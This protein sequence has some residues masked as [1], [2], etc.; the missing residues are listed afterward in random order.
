MLPNYLMTL[1]TGTMKNKFSAKIVAARVVGPAHRINN[2]PC[3]DY[4]QYARG[5]NLIAVLSDGAGS[6]EHGKIGARV[7]CKKLCDLLKNADFKNIENEIKN[8]ISAAR[9]DLII[10]RFNK[11]KDEHGLNDF[12][13][14]LVGVV[15]HQ[16]RGIFFHIGDGAALSIHP[17]NEVMVSRPE[18]GYFSCETFFFTQNCWKSNLRFTRF[19]QA[20]VIFLMSDG[21]TSFAFR[22]D[23]QNIETKFINPINDF[24]SAEPNQAK[25]A[26]ALGNTL[27]T[28]KAQQL[29]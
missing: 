5:K 13:A 9:Q 23:F 29:N 10:H 26:K 16:D 20:K 14:T 6:S 2:L 18:N 3:Q 7:L 24:L 11:S 21:V 27:N 17:D 8:A 19:N 25:A 12:A 15:Y 1:V 4:C 22:P 28:P